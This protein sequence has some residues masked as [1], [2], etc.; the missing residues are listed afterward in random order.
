MEYLKVFTVGTPRKRHAIPKFT[1]ISLLC[2]L[3]IDDLLLTDKPNQIL[4]QLFFELYGTLVK[5]IQKRN[6]NIKQCILAKE[7]LTVTLNY[8]VEQNIF[9]VFYDKTT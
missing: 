6:T 8:N 1:K 7:R 3:L 4:A 2:T 5:H 9:H